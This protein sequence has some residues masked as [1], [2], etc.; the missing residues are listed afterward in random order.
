[1]RLIQVKI[2]G[3]KHLRD[4]SV[5]FEKPKESR[6]FY[7]SIPIRFFIGLNGSGKSAFLEGLCFLFSRLV[8][9]EVPGF[10]FLLIYEIRRNG[11]LYRVEAANGTD[12]EK[13]KIR[14]TSDG[15]TRTFRSFAGRRH[16]LPDYVLTCASGSNNNF[17][18]IM[19]RSP[20]DSLQSD[21]FDASLLGKST[22]DAQSRRED[23]EKTLA[24]L[25]RLDENPIC[26]FIDEQT[27]VLALAAF[28]AVFP[29][30]TEAGRTEAYIKC[31]QSLLSVPDSTPQPVS[32]SLTLDAKKI[33]EL[34]EDAGRYGNLFDDVVSEGE[35]RAHLNAWNTTRLYQ[36][37]VADAADAH[38]DVVL[39]YLFEP[40]GAGGG[41]LCVRSLSQAFQTPLRF[42]SK[43]MLARNKG[44]VKE[45]HISFRIRGTDHIL[46]E[47]AL[48]E[49]EYMLLVRLW[50][51]AMGSCGEKD[52]QCLYLLDEPDVYLNERWS[53][54]FVSMIQQMY[55]GADA[56]HE[57]V[58]ATH[59]SLILTDA[60]PDQLYY[61]HLKN[62]QVQCHNIR[63]STFGG[64]RNEIMQQLFRTSHPVGSYAYSKIDELLK[65]AANTE[66]LEELLENVGSGYLRLRLLDKIHRMRED[67]E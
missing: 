10:D 5:S 22:Q 34:D 57:I 60:F 15:E 23:I 6:L 32:L 39:T 40:Y 46:E 56:F 67:G 33:T 41:T 66:E 12:G 21:L 53:V 30:G 29:E 54:D 42:L 58:V 31:R 36:D 62:G 26:L 20:R 59:S 45:A 37:E 17:F 48:S 27:S 55:D 14:V 63:A 51:L 1:M 44:I 38:G 16:L 25:R 4:V 8:Q 24:S 43:L 2:S 52:L 61:F 50:L 35:A 19:V 64:S 13:F 28:L 18:D 11:M 47:N 49:G 65:T 7:G 9:D 3:Y